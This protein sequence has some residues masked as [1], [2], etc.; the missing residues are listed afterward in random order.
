M[1]E[2]FIEKDFATGGQRTEVYIDY[3]LNGEVIKSED[4]LKFSVAKEVAVQDGDNSYSIYKIAELN[5]VVF[6][7]LN[8][9][10]RPERRFWEDFKFR[11]VSEKVFNRYVKYLKTKRA[12]DYIQVSRSYLDD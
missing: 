12:S 5:G 7:G 6:D 11:K 2:S 4:K 3:D 9:A 8:G 10:Y 1:K